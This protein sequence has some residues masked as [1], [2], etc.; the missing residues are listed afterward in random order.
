MVT[1]EINQTLHDKP[2]KHS[3]S[4]HWKL[5]LSSCFHSVWAPEHPHIKP[6]AK[7]ASQHASVQPAAPPT[8]F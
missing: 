3:T 2:S 7:G 6:R 5:I 1:Q 4:R 8:L